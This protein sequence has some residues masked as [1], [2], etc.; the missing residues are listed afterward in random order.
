MAFERTAANAELGFQDR[1]GLQ[2]LEVILPHPPCWIGS[3]HKGLPE[4]EGLGEQAVCLEGQRAKG[5]GR[6]PGRCVLGRPGPLQVGML[7][8]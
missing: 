2:R 1:V 5:K 7:W 6:G 3:S 8:E 4:V